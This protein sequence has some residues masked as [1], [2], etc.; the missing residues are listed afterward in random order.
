MMSALV[1]DVL[2]VGEGKAPDAPLQETLRQVV[3]EKQERL[4]ALRLLIF[5]NETVEM[6]EMV[7]WYR[8]LKVVLR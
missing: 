7:D 4:L 2:H 8:R 5:R 3:L 6:I 1:V